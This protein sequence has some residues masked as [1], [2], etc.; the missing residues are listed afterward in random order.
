VLFASEVQNWV[1]DLRNSE[2]WQISCVALDDGGK[3]RNTRQQAHQQA[4]LVSIFQT[5]LAMPRAGVARP[6]LPARMAQAQPA[7][8]R[9]EPLV[10]TEE[11]KTS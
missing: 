10:A 1:N 7:A 5:G 6:A 2:S 3:N 8:A 11:W 4:A 9:Q